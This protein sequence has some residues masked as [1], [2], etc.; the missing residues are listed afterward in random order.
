MAATE[1]ALVVVFDDRL[2]AE[3]AMRDL[4]EA[5][6]DEEQIG[7]ALRGSEVSRGGMITDATGT[8]DARG[9]VAG[10]ATGAV[11]GGVL[12]V[13][14]SVL[15]PGG[16]FCGYFQPR[17]GMCDSGMLRDETVWPARGRNGAGYTLGVVQQQ[18]RAD[19]QLHRR[20]T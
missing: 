1:R 12:A 7:F 3:R 4:E 6:F 9:A 15:L 13:A 19:L 20:D 10:A 11:V 17:C 14:A 5:G 2:A 18:G 8:K 16:G